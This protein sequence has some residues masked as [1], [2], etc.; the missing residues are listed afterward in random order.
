MMMD[1]IH[2]LNED[3]IRVCCLRY[4]ATLVCGGCQFRMSV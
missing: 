4:D 1:V 3:S 2:T